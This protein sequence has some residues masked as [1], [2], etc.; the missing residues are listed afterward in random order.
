MRT[1]IVRRV[2]NGRVVGGLQSLRALAVG[3]CHMDKEKCCH[4]HIVM[5]GHA[6]SLDAHT[7]THTHTHTHTHTRTRPPFL[8]APIWPLLMYEYTYL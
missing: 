8:Q 6:S 1:A 7:V 4:M 2:V 5:S 3:V